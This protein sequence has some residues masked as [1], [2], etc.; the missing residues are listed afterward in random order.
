MVIRA[1]VGWVLLLGCLLGL[2]ILNRENAWVFL[3]VLL[4]WVVWQHRTKLVSLKTVG[5]VLAL[6]IGMSLVLGPVGLRNYYVGG[7]FL[8]T[9]SQMGPN[10]FI[11]NHSGASGQYVSLRPDRGDPR[12]E[13]TDARI[14]AEKAEGR[15]MTPREVSNYWMRRSY[16]DI[17]SDPMGWLRLLAKKWYL[18]W[19]QVEMVDG[20]GIRVHAWYSPVLMGTRW[21][22]NFGVLSAVAVAGAWLARKRLRELWVLYGM[23]L[24]FALAVTIFYVFARY[25]YPLVPMVTLFAAFGIVEGW[26][27]VVGR[28]Q[29]HGK[30]LLIATCL[31]GLSAVATC[32]SNSE[33]HSD[34]VTYFSVGTA[35]ND[36]GRCEE[37]MQ[38]L[39][40]AIKIKPDF[41]QAYVNLGTTAMKMKQWD[42]AEDHLREALRITPDNPVALQNLANVAVEKG[43]QEEAERIYRQAIQIDPFLIPA[44]QSLARLLVQRGDTAEAVQLMKQ[45][46]DADRQSPQAYSELGMM[47]IADKQYPAAVQAFEKALDL[48]PRNILV[49]NNYAW[50]LATGPDNVRDGYRAVELAEKVCEDVEYKTPEFIDTLA[51][52]Y[53]ELGQFDKAVDAAKKGMKLLQE[54]DSDEQLSAF[55]SRLK[56]YLEKQAYRDAGM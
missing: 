10:F 38:Q 24:A 2:L 21:I 19:N 32:W 46:A 22:L 28:R 16:D 41:A 7:E 42:L 18:T 54:S 39:Q 3:P 36:L 6:I 27:Y 4:A 17:L 5:S 13:R 25:R 12:F 45:A 52:A 56:L 35:L 50:L 14:L 51:A 49:A 53:A 29:A 31:G 34:E 1:T 15:S 37:A 11:G 47:L 44:L 43:D 26:R 40:E 55:E 9:T 48:S 8:L 23:T 20:E 30:E 33:L